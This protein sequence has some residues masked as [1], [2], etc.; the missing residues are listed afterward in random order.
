IEA[1]EKAIALATRFGYTLPNAYTSLGSAFKTLIEQTPNRRQ[2]KP[3]E[4]RLQALRQSAA[5]M[6]AKTKGSSSVPLTN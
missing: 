6:K 2:R 3:Y 4:S 1:D 5:K